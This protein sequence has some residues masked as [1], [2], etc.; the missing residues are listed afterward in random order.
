MYKRMPVLPKELQSSYELV[1][2][3]GRGTRQIFG[4]KFRVVD[5]NQ[6][7]AKKADRLIQMGFP[8]LRKVQ[9]IEDEKPSSKKSK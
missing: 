6:L 4:P 2:W 9:K 8:Y 5:L 1:N 7:T 3:P